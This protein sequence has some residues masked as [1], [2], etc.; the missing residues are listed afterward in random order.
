MRRNATRSDRA[1]ASAKPRSK[2]FHDVDMYAIFRVERPAH[3]QDAWLVN[4]SRGARPIRKSFSDYTYGGRE[5]ALFV[6]RAYRDAVLK[7]V[8]PLT[9]RDMRM[10]VRKN[11]PEGSITGVHFK[12]AS[13]PR[14][15]YWIARIEIEALEHSTAKRKRRCLTRHF[16]VARYG[17]AE[18]KR[19]AENERIRMVMAVD[20]GEDPALRSPAG[21]ALHE[22]RHEL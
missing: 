14:P 8:P 17:D 16:S 7:I 12:P 20:N 19:M 3:G 10:R 4:L 9:H 1:Q 5:P 21:L 2:A 13:G 18:A 11:R 6:A 15:A 22:I